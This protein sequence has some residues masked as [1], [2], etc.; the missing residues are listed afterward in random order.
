M[1][2]V[3]ISALPPVASSLFTDFGPF[4]QGGVTSQ[5]TLLQIATL[6]GFDSTTHLLSMARGGTNAN[7]TAALGAVPYSTASAFALVAPGTVG[8]LFRSGGAGAPTWTTATF[9][10]TGGPVGN[11]L[12]SDGTN[13]VSS[14]S[15]WPNTV[16]TV[17]KILRS[18]G[19]SNAYSTSTFAD[20]YTINT[21]LFASAANTVVGLA[22]A[23][24]AVLVTSA[25][26]V[27]SLSTV[28]PGGLT[29]TDP[30]LTQGIATKNYVDQTALNGTSVYAA[31][32]ATLGTVTQAG[33]GVGATLTNAGTQATFALDGVNPPVGSNVLIKNTATGMTAAN[34]GIYTVTSVGSG[35]TNWVLTRA[36]SYDTA[37]E[38]NNTGLIVIQNGSTLIGTAWYNA[39]T[40]VTVDTTNFSF[41]QFGNIT[42]P[43]S[44]ANG[45]TSASLTASNG[46]IFYS[47]A[48]AGAI[49]AGTATA[50]L[51]LL[52][53]SSTA[54]TWSVSPP[55]TRINIQTFAAGTFT[56]TPT[57]GTKWLT[58]EIVG[59]GGSGGAV[60]GGT[61]G[62]ASAAGGGAGGGY[63]RKT[64]TIAQLGATAALVVGAGGVAATSGANNGNAGGNSTFT[65][66]GAGA[67]LTAT[68]GGAG[69]GMAQSAS[70]QTAGGGTSGTGTG[71]DLNVSGARGGQGATQAAGAL[72]ISGTGGG[73]M[74]SPTAHLTPVTTTSQGSS[75]VGV[76]YGGGS[77]G[78][79]NIASGNAA[80]NAG[81]DG[82]CYITEY[83]SI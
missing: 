79:F 6:F 27:P 55:F 72:A 68:G 53:G 17:G 20:T 59:A 43:I 51:A 39:A 37:T 28:L 69:T 32:A 2:G 80:S 33:A 4:V 24:S 8:Q 41:S 23:N 70:A 3:K 44:L 18:N 40:I 26:G 13:Y 52:S 56:Y 71:G 31:S 36:T 11:I 15:L 82:I 65:P 50:G 60:S 61:A 67:V 78:A 38:I 25:G 54:P 47:T 64:Y 77:N 1:A 7:L 62:Q 12:I 19:A 14:T 81:A 46:G 9:P 42:F 45:G 83:I 22:T 10:T 76:G 75:A 73:T 63:S 66:A 48:S 57:T 74:F 5:A 49:L 16:G 30:T 35:A 34:E 58:T 21:L 29:T